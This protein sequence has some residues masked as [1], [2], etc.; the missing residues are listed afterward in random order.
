MNG[1]YPPCETCNK[2]TY[3]L[4]SKSNNVEVVRCDNCSQEYKAYDTTPLLQ[5]EEEEEKESSTY[6]VTTLIAF[7]VVAFLAIIIADLIKLTN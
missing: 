6:S 2:T 4:L 1:I 5:V 7:I 3:T